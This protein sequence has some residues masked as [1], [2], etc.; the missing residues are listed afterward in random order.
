MTPVNRTYITAWIITSFMLLCI[1]GYCHAMHRLDIAGT[2]QGSSPFDPAS[3]PPLAV[4]MAG[5]APQTQ[6][7]PADDINACGAG[8]LKPIALTPAPTQNFLTDI[9]WLF[10]SLYGWESACG[11][12][13][14][15]DNGRA[16]GPYHI[17]RQ[18]WAD[19]CEFGGVDWDYET[20]VF[21]RPHCEQV[22]KWYWQRHGAT[23]NRQRARMFWGGPDGC[24]EQETLDRWNEFVATY[25]ERNL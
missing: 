1:A 7:A 15:G 5:A 10:D 11:V 13:L 22:M 25:R 16:L 19:G 23:N 9:R 21:S 4:V 2:T 3:L 6:A 12:K 17:G 8:Y 18:F 14:V 24:E 20:L